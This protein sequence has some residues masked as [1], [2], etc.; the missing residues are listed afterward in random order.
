MNRQP[1]RCTRTQAVIT[2]VIALTCIEIGQPLQ[3]LARG[4]IEE[5]I[6]T[7]RRREE[8]LQETPIAVSAFDSD[9]LRAAQI[10][11][12]GDLTQNVPGLSRREGNK[13]AT[14]NIRGVSTRAAGVGA[15][16]GVGVY[17]DSIYIP[18]N[19]TQLV[20]VVKMESVQVLRG[21]QGTL[22]GKNTAGGAILLTTKKP[23][24]EYEGYA[25]ANVGDLNRLRLNGGVSGPIAGDYLFGGIQFD[26]RLEDGYREDA[27]TGID[28][29]NVD[30]KTVLGQLRLE[31]DN[32]VGD[33]ML[34]WGQVEEHGAPSNCF[35]IQQT[36]LGGFSAPGESDTYADV[37]ARSE[38]LVDDEK[39]LLDRSG[40]AYEVT[41]HMAGLTL[42][43]DFDDVT[44]KSITGL[45]YQDDIHTG[46]NDTD[47]SSLFTINNRTEVRRQL[48][49]NGIDATAEERTFMSQ[50]FQLVGDAFDGFLDYTLGLFYSSEK[51]DDTV[52]GN[53]IG[54]GGILCRESGSLS[55]CSCGSD[56]DDNVL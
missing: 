23:G 27:V 55:L 19:D 4:L 44:L 16:P 7:A 14:L 28:Y 31:R 43:W 52:A 24:P 36:A 49:A 32:F 33:L 53:M 38:A 12:V 13:D 46:S 40:L 51:I 2:T 39:V 37:C 41:N 22:F 54:P 3:T 6:V 48:Q 35:F 1:R 50:E 42:E 20:D 45:L 15:E 47:G 18:R 29:G 5:V 11:N 25:G 30:R 17:I 21:P 56:A 10:T 26:S 8:S 34:F 9:A